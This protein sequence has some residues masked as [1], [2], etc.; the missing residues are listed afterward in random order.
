M[1]QFDLAEWWTALV[2]IEKVFWGISIIFSVLFFI[3]FVLSAIGLDFDTDA[4]VD[5]GTDTGFTTDA[6]FTVFSVRSFIAFFTFFGW[7]GVGVLSGGGTS[8]W[9]V[10]FGMIAGFAAMFLVGYIMY[11]FTKLQ[12]NGSVFNPYEAID[13]I[14]TVY[15]RI[16]ANEGGTG[17]IQIELQGALKEIDAI[18]YE[19]QLI[20]TGTSIRVVDIIDDETMVVEPVDKY[21]EAGD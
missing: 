9:A 10:V 15:L 3:Q 21:L 6:S 17:K 7:A 16:P 20:P 1:M 11:A 13:T 14:G 4:D 2:T 18:S 19:K 5:V 8:L 12:D